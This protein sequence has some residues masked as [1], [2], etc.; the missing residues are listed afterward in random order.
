MIQAEIKTSIQ[1]EIEARV[2]QNIPE[3]EIGFELY[4]QIVLIDVDL[5]TLVTFP[6]ECGIWVKPKP[7]WID[8]YSD[9]SY[10]P[11]CILKQY[12]ENFQ[13]TGIDPKMES[14]FSEG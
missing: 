10:E 1:F 13:I 4:N 12:L 11:I 2:K 14:K 8:K 6:P 5:N 3:N 9:K 7:N